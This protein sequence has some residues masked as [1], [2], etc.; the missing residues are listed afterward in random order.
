MILDVNNY[1]PSSFMDYMDDKEEEEEF[2]AN[3]TTSSTFIDFVGAGQRSS[4]SKTLRVLNP[5][6]KQ[7]CFDSEPYMFPGTS[8]ADTPDLAIGKLLKRSGGMFLSNLLASVTFGAIST[9]SPKF[10]SVR[11]GENAFIFEGMNNYGDES[12]N[13][14]CIE[15]GLTKTLGGIY[16]VPPKSA[17]KGQVLKSSMCVRN[18][19]TL[20]ECVDVEGEVSEAYSFEAERAEKEAMKASKAKKRRENSLT[21]KTYAFIE[22][23]SADISLNVS[24]TLETI[25]SPNFLAVFFA[26]CFVVTACLFAISIINQKKNAAPKPVIVPVNIM[27]SSSE[28][29]PITTTRRVESQELQKN[30]DAP[31]PSFQVQDFRI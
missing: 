7:L 17:M 28:V 19:F 2:A 1:S 8:H 23:S 11:E 29:Q 10:G 4:K 18:S 3:S 22:R 16:F 25:T 15:P 24:G 31:P 5:T 14:I 13:I 21:A 20:L 26:V 9:P 30:G 12:D 27:E 6:S